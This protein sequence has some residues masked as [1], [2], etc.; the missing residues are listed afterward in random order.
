[1]RNKKQ[2]VFRR[3]GYLLILPPVLAWPAIQAQAVQ[4][5]QGDQVITSCQASRQSLSGGSANWLVADDQ[6][7]IFQNAN[8]NT[9][10][11]A[12]FL[13]G[14]A[15]FSASPKNNNGMTLFAN[16]HVSGEYNNGGAIFAKEGAN[17]R[18]NSSRLTQSF[19]FF[20]FE[21]IFSPVN[22]LNQPI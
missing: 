8:E 15:S 22:A 5:C 16:N 21:P 20:M 17:K 14:G 9:S 3:K 6:W 13:A 11:G 18:G 2:R 19:H 10:G 7:L 12:V 4:T 1:M